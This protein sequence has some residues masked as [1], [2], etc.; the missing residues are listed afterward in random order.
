MTPRDFVPVVITFVV[1]GGFAAFALNVKQLL[2]TKR[3]SPEKNDT[4]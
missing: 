1:V 3:Y 4:D 2:G